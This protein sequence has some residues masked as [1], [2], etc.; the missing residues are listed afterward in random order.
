MNEEVM[1]FAALVKEI[2]PE[3]A[4]RQLGE[5]DRLQRELEQERQVK[6]GFL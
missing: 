1:Q 6:I 2:T 3:E 4:A 5:R